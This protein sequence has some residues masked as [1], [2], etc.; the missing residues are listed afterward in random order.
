ME[1]TA[2]RPWVVTLGSR[3]LAHKLPCSPTVKRRDLMLSV[4]TT[5]IPEQ[6]SVSLET[7]EITAIP[8]IPELAL[9]REGSM[10]TPTVVGTKQRTLQITGTS[11]SRPWGTSWFSDLGVLIFRASCWRKWKNEHTTSLNKNVSHG[12]DVLVPVIWRVRCFVPTSV[13][14]IMLPSCA[15]ANSGITGMAVIFLVSNDTDSCSGMWVVATNCI[16]SLLVT[17][18]LQGS[19]WANQWL[20]C[21][22]SQCAS[23]VVSISYQRVQR[24]GGLVDN[25]ESGL[26][27]DSH[28]EANLLERRVPVG[29]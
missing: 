29:R 15:K 5:H 11:T 9:A 17:V 23:A 4:V 21:A 12:F 3:W 25:N 26:T 27:A 16:E 2:P 18:G 19:L 22:T 8:V 10:I 20:P 13:G 1:N 14:V 28:T 7:K 6:E 24:A